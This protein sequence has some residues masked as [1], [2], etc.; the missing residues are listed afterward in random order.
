VRGASYP[1]RHLGLVPASEHGNTDELLDRFASLVGEGMDIETIANA[2]R[3][4]EGRLVTPE[5]PAAAAGGNRARPFLVAVADDDAFCFHYRENWEF[6]RALGADVVYTSP[7]RDESL[8]AGADLLILPGGYPEEFADRLAENSGYMRSV[9]E[10]SRAGRIYAECGGM[11]YLT[12]G[13]EYGGRRTPMAG[14]IGADTFM[15]PKLRRFG[16]VEARALKD[17]ILFRRGETV[18]AHEFHYS[19]ISGLTPE[20]FSVRRVSRKDGV[21]TD[22]FTGKD[23]GLLATYLHINFWSCPAA[24]ARLVS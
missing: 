13:I 14:V 16:Y 24:A 5:I 19:D 8:P 6:L 10:F 1:S 21:W 17:N 2:A 20:V 23:G 15:T 3:P 7:L 18:R 4:P 11:M 9:R 12:R 22:G